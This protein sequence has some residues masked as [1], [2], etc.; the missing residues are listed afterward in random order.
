MIIPII[1]SLAVAAFAVVQHYQ[2]KRLQKN[3]SVKE[4]KVQMH[5]DILN[6]YDGYCVAQTTL[7]KANYNVATVIANPNILDQW[8]NELQNSM[9]VI[10]QAYNR[11]G[12]LL[13]KTDVKLREVLKNIFEK[14]QDF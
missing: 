14:Y 5:G 7:G 8:L 11:A 6:I 13:P 9:A 12:L 1:I 10:C 4:L 3:I 2:N